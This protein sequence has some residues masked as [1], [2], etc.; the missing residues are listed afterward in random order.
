MDIKGYQTHFGGVR[1]CKITKDPYCLELESTRHSCE[2]N[3]SSGKRGLF[4]EYCKAHETKLDK[5]DD[6]VHDHY[7]LVEE[8]PPEL[9]V[10]L[11][12]IRSTIYC[13]VYHRYPPHE[14][15]TIIGSG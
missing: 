6:H 10:E 4:Q 12:L 5:T 2:E 7:E 15:V 13:Q 14:Y 11:E 9:Q 1:I 3:L 8:A